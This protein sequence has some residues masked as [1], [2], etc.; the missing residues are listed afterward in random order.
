MGLPDSYTF[1]KWIE[2]DFSGEGFKSLGAVMNE[3]LKGKLA[4]LSDEEISEIS[5]SLLPRVYDDL[6]RITE[7]YLFDGLEPSFELSG[8]VDEAYLRTIQSP[9]S[10]LLGKLRKLN[11]DDFEEFCVS[12][13][14]KLGAT[15]MKVDRAEDTG[16]DF[17]GTNINLSAG[18]GP[19]PQTS[20]VIVVGQAKRYSP[21]QPIKLPQVQK[22]VGS[23][24]EK[25][26]EMRKTMSERVGILAPT[27]L[28]FWTT[29]D[30]N[31]PAKKYV[32]NMGIWYLNGIGVA[33]LADRTGLSL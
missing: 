7:S 24:T 8:E 17:T 18:Y 12:L 28:A 9:A 33:Q 13:L 21:D 16:I 5:E 14:K 25:L 4:K 11:P 31:L 26:F 23:A 1:A 22:F 29:S 2:S 32:R 30:F 19:F 6:N 20:K 15:A 10:L 3:V 27:V